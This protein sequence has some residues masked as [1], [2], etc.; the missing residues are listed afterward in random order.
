MILMVWGQMLNFHKFSIFQFAPVCGFLRPFAGFL[1]PFCGR[2]GADLL[3]ICPQ[4]FTYVTNYSLFVQKRT[5]SDHITAS[6]VGFGNPAS[7]QPSVQHAH[8]L[9][10]APRARQGTHTQTHWVG[11]FIEP[12]WFDE[13][14][15][16]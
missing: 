15:D 3:P 6:P 12:D 14:A 10:T 11:K 8:D 13:W 16:I 9:Q 7:T 1:R 2:F 4:I 5:G